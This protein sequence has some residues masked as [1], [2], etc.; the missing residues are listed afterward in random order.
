VLY[1]L[2]YPLLTLERIR[3]VTAGKLIL[4]TNSLRPCTNARR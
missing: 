2:R 3:S 1:H 4:E